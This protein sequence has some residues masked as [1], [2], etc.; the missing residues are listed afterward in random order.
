MGA[1]K[2]PASVTTVSILAVEGIDSCGRFRA[3]EGID[4]WV[5]V[6]GRCWKCVLSEIAVSEHAGTAER[7][8]AAT[9]NH[10]RT[11]VEVTSTSSYWASQGTLQDPNSRKPRHRGR[12]RSA[13]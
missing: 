9:I 12:L 1:T 10:L 11:L 3:F 2:A 6:F 4:S 5:V 13:I 7:R 8:E